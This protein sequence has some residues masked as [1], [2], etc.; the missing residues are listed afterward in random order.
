MREVLDAVKYVT[1]NEVPVTESERR[2]GD[3]AVLIASN[4]KA[5]GLLDW[6][7]TRD[8]ESMVE[9]AWRFERR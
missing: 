8:L 6:R 5:A 3:V 1:G 2:A 4:A 9:D 7:P